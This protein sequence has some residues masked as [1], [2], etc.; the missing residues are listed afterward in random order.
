MPF[1]YA[2]DRNQTMLVGSYDNMVSKQNPVRIIDLIADKMIAE[3]PEDFKRTKES[4]YGAPSYLTS[5]LLKLFLYG[6]FNGISSSRA[7]EK[8]TYRNKEVIWLLGNLQPDHWTISTFRKDHGESISKATKLFRKF[9]RSTEYMDFKQ[10]A[11]DGTKVKANA[12]RDMLTLEKIERSIE[13]IDKRIAEYLEMLKVNDIINDNTEEYLGSEIRESI[14]MQLI[15]KIAELETR[16]EE[17]NA[18]KKKMEEEGITR[19]SPTDEEAKLMKSRDGKQPCY[20]VQTVVDSKYHMISYCEVTTDEADVQLLEPITEAIKEEYGE[21]PKEILADKGYYNPDQIE[22]VES[23]QQ[24]EVYV[25]VPITKPSNTEIT[26]NYDAEKDVY[27]CSEGKELRLLTRNKKCRNSYCDVYQGIEC[28][29][30]PRKQECTTSKK[31]R[32]IKRYKNQKYRDNYKNKMATEEGKTKS[33]LRKTIVE[34]PFGTIKFLMGKIPILLRGKKK[35]STEMNLYTT[36]YNL[37]RLLNIETTDVL[38]D[39]IMAFNWK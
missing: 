29:S 5:T 39:K 18:Y 21:L 17:L 22:K 33:R 26:F 1:I 12:R 9:L 30:C 35:V 31:G 20:N 37:K 2:E 19:I 15:N 36:A 7:L 3:N 24:S 34:H 14:D 23:Y 16:V 27:I 10:A 11:Y 13:G 38:I 4:K 6:Y 28:M 8:E 32:L 25:P